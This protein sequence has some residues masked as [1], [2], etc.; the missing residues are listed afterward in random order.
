MHDAVQLAR[1]AS[2]QQID[3]CRH[4]RAQAIANRAICRAG[5]QR[6]CRSVEVARP[7]VVA[8]EVLARRLIVDRV[9]VIHHILRTPDV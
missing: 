7:K 2:D 1:K 4:A 8:N 3:V 5:A 9:D 6:T